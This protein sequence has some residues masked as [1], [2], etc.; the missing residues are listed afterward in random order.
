LFT[1]FRK[2]KVTIRGI[3]LN[4][5]ISFV[6]LSFIMYFLIPGIP[7]LAGQ[8]ELLFTNGFG[9]PFNTGMIVYFTLF[10]GLLIWG[11]WYTRKKKKPVLN[12][13]LLC[14]AFLFIGYS[15]FLTL[16]IRSNAGTPINEDAP[17]DAVSLV[18]FL[19]SRAIRNMAISLRAVLYGTGHRLCDGTPIYKRDEKSGKYIVID[20]RKG[21]VLIYDPKFTTLF[22][23]MWEHATEKFPPHF[24]GMGWTRR[25]G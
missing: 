2:F 15:S 19:K 8:F 17:K 10:I 14:L 6:I 4:L 24:T 5:L 1:I 3:L 16:V 21:T 18:S 13:L 23:R 22:P 7:Q 11:L 20:D 12:T 25:P 9:L